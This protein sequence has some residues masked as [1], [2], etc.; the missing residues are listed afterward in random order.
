MDVIPLGGAEM[1]KKGRRGEAERKKGDAESDERVTLL[2]APKETQS[3]DGHARA[4]TG[5]TRITEG[6]MF[7]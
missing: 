3:E 2:S 6:R 7:F 1:R 4:E 5:Y